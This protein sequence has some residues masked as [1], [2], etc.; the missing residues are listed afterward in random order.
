MEYM[1]TVPDKYFDL[2]IVDPP[3]GIGDKFK[4]GK[5]GKMNFNEIVNK[6]WDKVPSDE[7]FNELQRVSK[8]QIIWGAN[9]FISRMPI[10]SSCWVVWDKG[11]GDNDFADCELAWTSF[12][13]PVRKYFKS[14]IGSNAKEKFEKKRIHPTQKPMELYGYILHKF[15]KPTDKIIDTHFG[16]CSIGI[17]C[18]NFGCS[19]DA[20]EIDNE[21]FDKAYK[22]LRTHVRQLDLFK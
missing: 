19:L 5:T 15:A 7:Y 20:C 2:A 4:G 22:R 12:S 14:W 17:A 13:C 1:A 16:S 9:H 10:D 21:Y 18:H 3:Y 11:T 8:N 6:G